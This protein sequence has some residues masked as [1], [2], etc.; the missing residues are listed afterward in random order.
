MNEKKDVEYTIKVLKVKNEL[1]TCVDKN[2]KKVAKN[3]KVIIEKSKNDLM[4]IWN[5]YETNKIKEK[6]LLLK[7]I[8]ILKK[9]MKNIE[10]TNYI[11]CLVKNCYKN[12][13]AYIDIGFSSLNNKFIKKFMLMKAK[14]YGID[15]DVK[16][17]LKSI[18]NQ[19]TIEKIKIT[20]NIIIEILEKL[21]KNNEALIIKMIRDNKQ[22]ITDIIKKIDII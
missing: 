12:Y 14:E 19:S 3:Y 16:K 2:C 5:D 11:K 8:N 15:S 7:M 9:N 18:K 21:Y 20:G 13:Q 4:K 6:E 1:M 10:Y 17:I 22:N